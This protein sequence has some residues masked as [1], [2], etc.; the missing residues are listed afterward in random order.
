MLNVRHNEKK[1][2]Q[3][4]GFRVVDSHFLYATFSRDRVPA[5][6]P[7][8]KDNICAPA[9]AFVF[10]WHR[11]SAT[12]AYDGVLAAMEHDKGKKTPLALASE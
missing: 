3:S 8:E 2:G 4:T 11:I 5:A 9:L 12:A 7:R 10:T 1:P 6:S